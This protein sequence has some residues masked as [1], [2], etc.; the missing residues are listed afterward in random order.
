MKNKKP[1]VL[2]YFRGKK[3]LKRQYDTAS[4]AFFDYEDYGCFYAELFDE[5]GIKLSAYP[6][7]HDYK[8]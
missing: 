5:R 6:I 4:G 7:G 8:L 1:Y 3:R 2:I